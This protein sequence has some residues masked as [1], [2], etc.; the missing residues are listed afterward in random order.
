M[1]GVAHA[2]VR[3]CTSY[4]RVMLF[5][6]IELI[7][8]SVPLHCNIA[9]RYNPLARNLLPLPVAIAEALGIEDT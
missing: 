7:T 9:L 5:L 3:R 1:I 2:H 4:M 8:L 6:F